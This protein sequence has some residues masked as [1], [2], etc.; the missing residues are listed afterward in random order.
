MTAKKFDTAPSRTVPSC[1]T[2]I[3]SNAP[4][5]AARRFASAFASSIVVLMLH[6]CQRM[7]S[8]VTTATPSGYLRGQDGT[9]LSG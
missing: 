6:R 4:A 9:S 2:K 5:S 7:S 8:T 1:P 3:A